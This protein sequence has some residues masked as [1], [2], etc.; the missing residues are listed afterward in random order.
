M[1]RGSHRAAIIVCIALFAACEQPQVP[2]PVRPAAELP[3]EAPPV[4]I[5]AQPVIPQPAPE[6]QP[7][8]PVPPAPAPAA[9]KLAP[10]S[11]QWHERVA[12]EGTK[13]RQR[14]MRVRIVY[15]QSPISVTTR[16]S[17]KD[18][19]GLESQFPSKRDPSLPGYAG[20]DEF[21]PNATRDNAPFLAKVEYQDPSDNA[22][23][24]VVGYEYLPR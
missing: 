14:G 7:P 18:R 16:V 19:F 15:R 4:R 13:N 9:N 22:W 11:I 5:A 21:L 2:L 20:I 12:Q 6:P 24:D 10:P 17:I 1:H 8:L 23:A 3:P